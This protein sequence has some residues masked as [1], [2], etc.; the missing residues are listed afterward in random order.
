MSQPPTP[1]T[2]VSVQQA[3]VTMADK[4]ATEEAWITPLRA[5]LE[6]MDAAEAAWKPAPEEASI[7]EIVRHI[8]AWTDW[9]ARFLQGQDS[10]VTDWP[11]VA[12]MDKTAWEAARQKL[13]GTLEALRAQIAAADPEILFRPPTPEVTQTTGL[14]GV[15]SI[16]IHNAY[17]AGQITKLRAGYARASTD[18]V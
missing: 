18:A 9:A 2:A 15:A 1:D 14:V 3:L 6:E 17:H 16:L 4:I 13:W 5:A 12:V 7:W 11:P 10:D 8:T